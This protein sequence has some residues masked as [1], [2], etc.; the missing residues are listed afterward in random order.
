MDFSERGRLLAKSLPRFFETEL[1]PC[2]A[3]IEDDSEKYFHCLEAIRA[4]G[5]F[6]SA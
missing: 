2:D 1:E 3:A 5:L 6:G 4:C